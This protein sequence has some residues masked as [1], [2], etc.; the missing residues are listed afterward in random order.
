MM[1]LFFYSMLPILLFVLSLGG[2][3]ASTT[4]SPFPNVIDLSYQ[5]VQGSS[6]PKPLAK[7][8]YD[9]KT[10]RS[11]VSSWTPPNTDSKF[12]TSEPTSPQLL[13]I[14]LPNGSSTLTRVATFNSSLTQ[15]ISLHLSPGDGTVY[16]ASISASLAAAPIHV[17]SSKSKAQPPK[18]KSTG[19]PA[20]RDVQIQLIP[21]IPGP[22][23]KLNSRKP[24]VIG[25]DGK[26]ITPEGAVP[27]KSF[28]QKYWWVF[29]L[30]AVLALAGGGD[31]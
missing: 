22:A 2:V 25:A 14:L 21:P 27:E 15:T 1:A 17:S 26:E 19:D 12:I 30:V 10:L 24:P 6:R 20:K 4:A 11:S 5:F 13:R 29:V 7:V 16:S 3:T 18:L 28:Y 9:P 8:S 31:K 23:P